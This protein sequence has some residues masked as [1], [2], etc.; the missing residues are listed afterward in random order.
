[1]MIPIVILIVIGIPT[2]PRQSLTEG[3]GSVLVVGVVPGYQY[4]CIRRLTESRSRFAYRVRKLPSNVAASRGARFF[5]LQKQ[6]CDGLKHVTITDLAGDPCREQGEGAS[7]TRAFSVHPC[8][9]FPTPV[10][11]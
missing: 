11:V 9:C 5:L 10:G 2:L 3:P 6:S 1:M 7:S 8:D 4:H